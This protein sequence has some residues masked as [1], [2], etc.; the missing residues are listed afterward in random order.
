M[1]RSSRDL[2]EGGI[3][4]N[5]WYLA[6]PMMAGNVLENAFNIVDMI[7]VGKLGPSAIAAVGMSGVILHI[8]F[9]IV[10]GIST[11][12]VA[13]V[14][15][16]IGA[17][18]AS[19]AEQVAMQSLF[20]G[21]FCYAVVAAVGYPLA[22]L[23]LRAL[24][25]A[26]EVVLLG[27]TYIRIMFLGA[28]TMI[29]SI[30]MGSVLRA[31]GDAITPLKIL[32]VSTL[33]NIGLD[34]LLIFGWWRFPRLGVAGSALATAIAR[35]IGACILL[36]IVLRG[37]TIIHLKRTNA[38]ID[39]SMMRRILRIGIFASIQ[40]ILRNASGVVLIRLV[41]LYGTFAVAAHVV[42]MRL[43]MIV[44]MPGFALAIAASALVGQNLG[45][46]K[47]LRAERTAW[48]TA[49]MGFGI[50]TL[51]G[52]VYIVF[53]PSII[54]VFNTHPE[55]IETGTNYLHIV[56]GAIGFVGLSIILGRALNGAGDTVSPMVITGIGLLALRLGL[57]LLFS[58]KLR[59][60]GIWFGIAAST[61]IQGLMMCFW[62]RA[63]KWKLKQV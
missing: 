5:I 61:V 17:K 56:A 24:G 58:W 39:F 4:R 53:A 48:I 46:D 10:I 47:P 38:K 50:M 7:F 41:A 9:V 25:A 60:T 37:R 32:T 19:E 36:W 8:L 45:A 15:R 44:M 1:N 33:L 57:C 20:L 13:L 42:G 27:T 52:I 3:I 30:L 6:L 43:H 11:G 14:A 29:L 55:V 21:V 35:G 40:A 54:G 23:M 12:T 59:L 16:F 34:P 63:G 18:K 22:P 62:F 26:Q 2:T 28:F 49:G 31:A 51:F